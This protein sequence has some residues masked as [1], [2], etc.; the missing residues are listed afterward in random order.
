MAAELGADS[1]AGLTRD[2]VARRQAEYGPDELI[3]A[4]GTLTQNRITV[5]ALETGGQRVDL[6]AN[7]PADAVKGPPFP[8]LLAAA[9]L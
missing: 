1:S 9:A 2:E 8:L 7:A 4:A 5:T 6:P 3:E